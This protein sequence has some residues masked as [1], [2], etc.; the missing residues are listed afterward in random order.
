MQ[1]D[2]LPIQARRSKKEP[3]KPTSTERKILQNTPSWTQMYSRNTT[4]VEA[5]ILLLY[6]EQ[7]RAPP[8]ALFEELRKQI[9]NPARLWSSNSSIAHQTTGFSGLQGTSNSSAEG[10]GYVKDSIKKSDVL[11]HSDRKHLN[12]TISACDR[13]L[14]KSGKPH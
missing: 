13:Y 9:L 8:G 14:V 11:H 1:G 10:G 3:L 6:R 12:N 4:L 7:R 2:L 5:T